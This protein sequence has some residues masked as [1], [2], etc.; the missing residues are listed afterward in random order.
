M[1]AG[2]SRI[3]PKMEPE[4]SPSSRTSDFAAS[5]PTRLFAPPQRKSRNVHAKL[6]QCRSDLA[7]NAGFIAV[8]QIKNRPLELR[9]DRNSA[10][11]QHARR[12]IVQNRSLGRKFRWRRSRA[13]PLPAAPGASRVLGNPCSRR[14]VSSSTVRPRDAATCG[15]FTT[16]TF[17]SSTAFK[18]PVKL[19]FAASSCQPQIP[20]PHTESG[21][22][23]DAKPP[24]C[25]T[26]EPSRS[27]SATYG[28]PRR[29][30]SGDN[31][32]KFTAL[33]MTPSAR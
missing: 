33:R 21:F 12:A 25:T 6:A 28:R 14:R 32:G 24:P 20:H 16:F 7:D 2:I 1:I 11:L 22:A 13:C 8:A 30:W 27:A 29:Y 17:S 15:A 26:S 19:R 4:T 31:A 3:G 23:P 18:E 10:D 5:R 9:L